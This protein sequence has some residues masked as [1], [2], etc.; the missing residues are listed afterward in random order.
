M[1]CH[2]LQMK[3][4]SPTS[5]A[6]RAGASEPWDG[7]CRNCG[8]RSC[9]SRSVT[10]KTMLLMLKPECFDRAGAGHYRFRVS[11][12]KSIRRVLSR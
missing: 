3:D 11:G 2:L 1:D 6:K 8:G 10:R 4:D 12:E 7:L 5:G 9:A